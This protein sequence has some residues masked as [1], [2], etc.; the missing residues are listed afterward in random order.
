MGHKYMK[1]ML[2]LLVIREMQIKPT[3]RHLFIPNKLTKIIKAD[4]IKCG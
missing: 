4:N 2:S 3:K 1:N